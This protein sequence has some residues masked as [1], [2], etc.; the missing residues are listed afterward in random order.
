MR[1][2][3]AQAIK[4]SSHNGAVTAVNG[5][6]FFYLHTAAEKAQRANVAVKIRGVGNIRQNGFEVRL[7]SGAF[8]INPPSDQK[9]GVAETSREAYHSLDISA[10]VEAVAKAAIEL[11]KTTPIFTDVELAGYMNMQPA[12]ISARRND[13]EKS[14]VVSI[15]GVGY[16]IEHAGRKRNPS[17]KTANTWVLVAVKKT[18]LFS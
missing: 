9:K 5:E 8:K 17:G 11:A 14:G 2:W 12:I 4:T 15:D 3:Y 6:E 10:S 7:N 18:D 13:I 16:R 1:T